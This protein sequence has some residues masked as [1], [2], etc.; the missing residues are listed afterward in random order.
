MQA[1][2]YVK[3]KVITIMPNLQK[4]PE[5]PINLLDEL[6]SAYNYCNAMKFS[7][8]TIGLLDALYSQ[9]QELSGAANMQLSELGN[10][11]KEIIIC[12]NNFLGDSVRCINTNNGARGFYPIFVGYLLLRRA[13]ET[14]SP[15]SA[16][17]WLKK[18]LETKFATGKTI[19]VLWGVKID[20]EINLTKDIKIIP[21]DRLPESHNKK[22]LM[23]VTNSIPNHLIPTSFDWIR[24]NS[25]LVIC[26]RIEPFVYD[27]E[28]PPNHNADEYTKTDELLLDITLVLTIVGPRV[29]IPIAQWFTFDDPDLE[30][31]HMG[32]RFGKTMEVLP[33][34]IDYPVLNHIEA[35]RIVQAY[36]AIKGDTRDKLRVALQRLNQS[37]R[38]SASGIGD[39]AVELATAFETMLGDNG[40]T[41]MT[42]KITVRAVRLLGGNSE[43][44]IMNASILKKT[45]HVRS[46]LV[47]TG[48]VNI[49]KPMNICKNRMSISDIIDHSTNMCID[50]IKI[51]ILRGSIP[52]WEIFDITEQSN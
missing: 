49:D 40:N 3:F 38:R 30:A 8:D 17:E 43:I 27:P 46:K 31:C 37:L 22:W 18:V 48:H 33:S 2:I 12:D 21:V 10:K 42:H 45:Y 4:T 51:I 7:F 35:Q 25:A 47:H 44:R 13:L 26:N 28:N 50:L 24:P 9:N 52:D 19:H 23:D 32:G 1:T 11:L 15:E 39:R 16:I 5:Y 34:A 29:P 20:Q 14:R 41:E 36:I 6:N